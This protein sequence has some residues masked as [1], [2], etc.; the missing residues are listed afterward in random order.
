MKDFIARFIGSC[1]G[2]GYVPFAPGTVT[3]LAAVLF[4][5]VFPRFLQPEYALAGIALVC[6]AGIWSADIMEKR[7]GHDPSQ[8]TIDELAGQWIALLF[9]PGGW[10]TSA[11]AFAAFRFFDIAKPEPV[12]SSQKLPGAWGIMADDLIAGIY[13][14]LSVR[15]ALWLLSV[16]SIAPSL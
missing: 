11:L 9:L 5:T 1:A 6:F 13:A 12:N 7:Y 4:F 14:N 15:I 8:V 2:L 10:I 16:F 3:S